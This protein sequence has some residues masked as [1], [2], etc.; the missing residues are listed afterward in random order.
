MAPYIMAQAGTGRSAR[1]RVM[2]PAA[3]PWITL[4]VLA[5]TTLRYLPFINL[6]LAVRF[7]MWLR[8]LIIRMERKLDEIEREREDD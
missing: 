5:I 1:R 3:L 2:M 8:D 6:D 7:Q 4:F